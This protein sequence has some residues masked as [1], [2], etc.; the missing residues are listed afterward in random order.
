MTVGLTVGVCVGVGVLVAKIDVAVTCNP[1]GKIE[2]N[3]KFEVLDRVSKFS[4]PK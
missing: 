1:K 3:S 2:S 4:S